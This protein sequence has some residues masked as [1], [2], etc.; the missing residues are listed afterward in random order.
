MTVAVSLVLLA[1]V[2]AAFAGFRAAT[3][4]NAR[5]RKRRYYA[6][7]AARGLALGAIGMAVTATVILVPLGD[8]FDDLVVA[9][10][11][12][13]QVLLPFAAVVVLSMVAYWLLPMRESTFVI[14]V[15]LGPFTLVRPLV[16]VAAV[17]WAGLGTDDWLVRLDAVVAAAAVLAV[18]PLTHHRWYR[19]PIGSVG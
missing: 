6:R 2:D 7:A 11:L 19:A 16:V 12:M 9:G 17:V 4:R 3:G 10:V 13:G 14:L 1:L 18:E 5:I 15:G 8:R